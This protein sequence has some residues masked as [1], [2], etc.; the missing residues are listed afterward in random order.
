MSSVR[1]KRPS[2]TVTAQQAG[3]AGIGC[4]GARAQQYDVAL[5][6]FLGEGDTGGAEEAGECEGGGVEICGLEGV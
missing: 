2:A 5:F 1:E 6:G 4:H 3:G